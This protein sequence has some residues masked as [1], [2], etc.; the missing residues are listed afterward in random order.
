[1]LIIE[2]K[3]K[4]KIVQMQISDYISEVSATYY[5]MWIPRVYQQARKRFSHWLTVR[6][7]K[8]KTK[9]S[10]KTQK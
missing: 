6:P 7:Y 10:K 5:P 3:G 1:M 9:S 4:P 2:Y 8:K